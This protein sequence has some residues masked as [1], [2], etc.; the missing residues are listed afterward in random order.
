MDYKSK[1]LKYKNKY[2]ILK[3]Q[4]GG[5]TVLEKYNAIK[6]DPLCLSI[7]F[8]QHNGECWNDS[9]QQFFLFQDGIKDQVQKKL[10]FL[11]V[12]EIIELAEL[13]DRKKYLPIIF[14]KHLDIYHKVITTLKK[15][16]YNFQ[17][18][19]KLYFEREK[20]IDRFKD[21]DM[22]INFRHSS[23]LHKQ[24]SIKYAINGA[25]CGLKTVRKSDF[26][27]IS[28]DDKHHG[29][30]NNE[31]ILLSIFLSYCLLDD[32]SLIFNEKL[33][34]EFKN[35]DINDIISVYLNSLVKE[36]EVQIGVHQTLFFTCD[37]N[38]NYYNDE[39][40]IN[41]TKINYNKLLQIIADNN[42]ISRKYNFIILDKDKEENHFIIFADNKYQLV[43]DDVEF[44]KNINISD[45]YKP[46]NIFN[47]IHIYIFIK[48]YNNDSDNDIKIK[49]QSYFAS[50][51]QYLIT[52]KL[53]DKI[54]ES[55]EYYLS[56][57][58]D[59]NNTYR[60]YD[61]YEFQ[62]EFQNGYTTLLNLFILKYEIVEFLLLQGSTINTVDLKFI[63][64]KYI[65]RKTDDILKI[66][67]L[68]FK[69]M[70]YDEFIKPIDY[71][72]NTMLYFACINYNIKLVALIVSD[73]KYN[74]DY[75]Y[76]EN[77]YGE[78]PSD[79]ADR[80]NSVTPSP[81]EE[82]VDSELYSELYRLV[83]SK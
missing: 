74:S 77:N 22:L 34:S 29:A 51:L 14:T 72:G 19:F 21:D 75:K 58:I 2:L 17:E 43:N 35:I 37:D 56:I 18:R 5:E 78:S 71:S 40:D 27:D 50:E 48:F 30:H 61:I 31:T 39:L 55:L 25:I 4:I 46:K 53:N 62:Y 23:E 11:S 26:D 73:E 20:R 24:K 44:I 36:M 9:I 69:H 80:S 1:Y 64:N 38:K 15:Y 66:I 60:I 68:L 16:L 59:I 8:K 47:Y 67:K 12:D 63:F 6:H 32:K 81:G 57:G 49:N 13:R 41:I 83:N 42:E 33:N 52:N 10:L 79:I 45:Y 3:N 65:A 82:K 7:G 76:I 54:I 70:S 28:E